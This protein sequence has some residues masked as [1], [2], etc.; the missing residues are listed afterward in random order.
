MQHKT[1]INKTNETRNTQTD[2]HTTQTESQTNR[3]TIVQFK[4]NINN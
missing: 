4:I 2:K 3:N 1:T